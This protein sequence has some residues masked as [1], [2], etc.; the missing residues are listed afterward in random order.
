MKRDYIYLY[1]EDLIPQE[2]KPISEEWTK[3]ANDYGDVGSCVL[4]AGFLFKFKGEKYKLPPRSRW[5][6]S[7]SWEI[8]VP[9]IKEKLQEIGCTELWFD[10]GIM[11]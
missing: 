7:C 1:N 6:G 10:W 5:Q 4:G 11:D 9:Q 2:I 3:L 8:F